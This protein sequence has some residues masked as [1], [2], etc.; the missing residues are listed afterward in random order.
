MKYCPHCKIE[1]AESDFYQFKGKPESW[2][3]ACKVEAEHQRYVGTEEYRNKK[4]S[5]AYDYRNNLSP[6]K[7]ALYRNTQNRNFAQ[8]H[9]KLKREIAN[10]RY[11]LTRTG[12]RDK[13]IQ[14]EQG[15]CQMCN[16]QL[17]IPGTSYAIH[18]IDGNRKNNV[19]DN[20][21]LLCSGCHC[22]K[23]QNIGVKGRRVT[24]A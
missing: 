22:V 12:L 7:R 24:F 18:H 6:E 21:E 19:L 5:Y 9:R 1:K 3:K 10:T 16:T 23:H 15:R 13:I 11:L 2:C 20:L 17:S 8:T 14:R 4:L